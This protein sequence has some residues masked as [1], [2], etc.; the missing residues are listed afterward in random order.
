MKYC[1]RVIPL[2]QSIF[3]SLQI[4]ELQPPCA[5][6]AS[7]S[8]LQCN[9]RSSFTICRK[10]ILMK[11]CLYI[12]LSEKNWKVHYLQSL[13]NYFR[14]LMITFFLYNTRKIDIIHDRTMICPVFSP[15]C[16]IK[17]FSCR[18]KILH[19]KHFKESMKGSY[20]NTFRVKM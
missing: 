20:F 2:L 18:D 11:T 15:T 17:S 13:W 1:I 10:I 7:Y 19:E 12:N 8:I 6:E 16:P 5:G 14:K 3:S 9:V 4:V